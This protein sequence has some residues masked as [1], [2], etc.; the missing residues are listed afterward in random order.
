MRR[1]IST[2]TFFLLAMLFLPIEAHAKILFEGFYKLEIKGIHSGYRS[3]VTRLTKRG[4]NA[5]LPITG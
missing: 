3:F 4:M 5:H 1:Q 2:R